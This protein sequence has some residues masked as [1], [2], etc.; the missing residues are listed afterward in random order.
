LIC[1]LI[2]NDSLQYN[3]P[4][5]T[6]LL[7]HCKKGKQSAQFEIYKLYY[8]A[9][10]NTSFRILKNSFEAEDV[11]QESFLVAFTKLGTF[12]GEVAFGSWLKR[13]VINKSISQL[14]KNNKFDTITLDI[15]PEPNQEIAYAAEYKGLSV[16]EIKEAI[17]Q[18]KNN[19]R[20]VLTLNL[21]EGY[22]SEEI[23]E[24]MNISYQN[25]RTMLSR[26]RSSLRKILIVNY[27]G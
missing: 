20:L 10:Y 3:Q 8:K 2:R 4:H 6:K 9:M 13:I 21:I 19:Y 12:K 5:I 23:S 14:R 26:A 27:E 18:L 24:I 16:K 25:S 15:V 17:A 1:L 11:M 22:D 7:K